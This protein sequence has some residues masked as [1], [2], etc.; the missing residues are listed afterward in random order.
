MSAGCICI[1]RTKRRGGQNIPKFCRRH[2]WKPPECSLPRVRPFVRSRILREEGRIITDGRK[3]RSE[4]C[5]L[6]LQW[7]EGAS[8]YDVFGFSRDGTPNVTQCRSIIPFP[9]R[10]SCIPPPGTT[11]LSTKSRLLDPD[12][13]V[14]IDPLPL[15]CGYIWKTPNTFFGLLSS[16]FSH[17]NS[18]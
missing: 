12:F 6:S 8:A 16:P 3:T 7:G 11:P 10:H 5:P 2:I 13:E 17:R 14:S 1:L 9:V 4:Q 15:L 18:L